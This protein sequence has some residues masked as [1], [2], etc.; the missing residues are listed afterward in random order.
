MTKSSL[1][2]LAQWT[3]LLLFTCCA[4]YGM[5]RETAARLVRVRV[6]FEGHTILSGSTSDNGHVDPD[7][8]WEYLKTVSLKPT[9]HFAK[10]KIEESAQQATLENTAAPGEFRTLIVDVAYGGIAFPREL[11]LIRAEPRKSSLPGVAGPRWR[12]AAADVDGLFDGRLIR[13]SHVTR[14]DHPQRTNR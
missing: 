8:V 11:K 1:R 13:R 12:V 3:F 4:A 10:L 6:V 9:E 7:G 5:S 2:R 14:L